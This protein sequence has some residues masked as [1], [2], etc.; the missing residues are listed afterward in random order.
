M[1][2]TFSAFE[3]FGKLCSDI[4]YDAMKNAENRYWDARKLPAFT[5]KPGQLR[6][7][8]ADENRLREEATLYSNAYRAIKSY[9]GQIDRNK[10]L[11][12]SEPVVCPEVTRWA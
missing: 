1:N 4:A 7:R 2:I 3:G 11:G 6:E 12:L 8:L 9:E 5:A 10:R